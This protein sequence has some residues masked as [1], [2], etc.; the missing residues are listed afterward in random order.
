MK[1]DVQLRENILSISYSLQYNSGEYIAKQ[2]DT[3]AYRII[4]SLLSLYLVH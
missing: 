3:R 1:L 2:T 4:Y